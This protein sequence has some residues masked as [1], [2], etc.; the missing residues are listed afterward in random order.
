M[1]TKFPLFVIFRRSSHFIGNLIYAKKESQVKI[2]R[3]KKTLI[4][5]ILE[6]VWLKHFQKYIVIKNGVNAVNELT[7]N[8]PCKLTV[9]EYIFNQLTKPK[10]GKLTRNECCK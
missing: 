7:G 3:W 8:K 1:K 2:T 5:V 10:I 4:N 9:N 6:W